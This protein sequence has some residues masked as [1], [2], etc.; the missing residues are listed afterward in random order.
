MKHL[1][2]M[3]EAPVGKLLLKFSL[4]SITM[5]LVNAL[6]NVVDRIVVGQYL[7]TE[8]LAAVTLAFPLM[9]VSLGIGLLAGAGA[10]NI[11]SLFL[12]EKKY[13]E[14]ARSLGSAAILGLFFSALL[15]LVTAGNLDTIL[16]L[17][18]ATPHTL[19]PAKTFTQVI[20]L[21]FIF[22]AVAMAVGM[23]IRAQGRAKTSM[24]IAVS[25][26]ILNAI[27]CVI[28]V[29]SLKMGIAGSAWA[30]VLAQ[31]FGLLVSSTFYLTPLNHLK[32]TRKNLLPQWTLITKIFLNGLTAFA[33]QLISI[34]IF[35][36][37]NTNMTVLKGDTGIAAIGIVNTVMLLVMLPVLGLVQ[38]AQPLIGFNLGAQNPHRVH[39]VLKITAF[40][41]TLVLTL[42]TIFME[43]FP[44]SLIWIFNSHDQELLKLGAL[45]LRVFLLFL[46]GYGLTFLLS[47]YYQSANKIVP[48]LLT[49]IGR[50]FLLI[51]LLLFLPK[52]LGLWGVLLTGPLSDGPFVVLSL[53]LLIREM[54]LLKV[55]PPRSEPLASS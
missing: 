21:G 33:L 2:Q 45:A 55:L 32:I 26:T 44:E 43:L 40:W 13:T 37:F 30:T 39:Q 20:L 15:T 53:I 12:G 7:G 36:Q 31:L 6:Y 29:G 4:P 47:Q 5:M 19:G 25:G 50:Q 48:S 23:P 41:S 35:I 22:Q 14:A 42:W 17:C 11:I 16:K 52:L 27:L 18:G 8:A 24:L 9:I 46:P 34:I 54:K 38:G 28:F 51:L 49:G 3:G 1:N 10:S